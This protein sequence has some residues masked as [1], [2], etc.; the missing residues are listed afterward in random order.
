MTAQ[1][2]LMW[3]ADGS[4]TDLIEVRASGVPCLTTGRC[5]EGRWYEL[6][7]PLA[8]EFGRVCFFE[9]RSEQAKKDE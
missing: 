7:V 2:V 6:D 8:Q 4:V 3:H 5:Y 9:K 1:N